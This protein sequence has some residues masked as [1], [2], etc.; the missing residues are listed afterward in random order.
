MENKTNKD[1]GGSYL[2]NEYEDDPELR[3]EITLHIASETSEIDSQKPTSPEMPMIQAI[4]KQDSSIVEFVKSDQKAAQDKSVPG[5]LKVPQNSIL[6]KFKQFKIRR[7]V[8]DVYCSTNTN[9][10][11]EPVIR[12]D[13]ESGHTVIYK[14]QEP[15]KSRSLFRERVKV[16]KKPPTPPPPPKQMVNR[17]MQTDPEKEPT[18]APKEPT[19]KPP[20]PPPP[21]VPPKPPTPQALNPQDLLMQQ[22]FPPQL[23]P[24]HPYY[25]RYLRGPV[26]SRYFV[27]PGTK[28]KSNKPSKHMPAI[29]RY[30][31]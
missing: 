4:V 13:D 8:N 24:L 6:T 7:G 15:E 29:R 20:P 26:V 31:I 12:I 17:E 22:G 10:T 5:L 1:T 16:K 18:P 28:I 27:P 14:I 30:Y 11:E 9:L 23:P 19:P 2:S 21:L 25:E 3:K